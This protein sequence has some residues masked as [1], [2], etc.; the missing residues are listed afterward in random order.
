MAVIETPTP[1]MI[2][3]YQAWLAG[4]PPQVRAVAERF[5]PWELY[6]LKTSKHRVIVLSFGETMDGRVELTVLV[7]GQ[8]NAV[9]FDRQV[10]GINPDDLEPCEL[11]TEDE[12]LG[13]MMT[14]EEV[15]ENIDALRAMAGIT[16]KD[17]PCFLCG[18][19]SGVVDTGRS[20][21]AHCAVCHRRGR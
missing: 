14:P 16:P 19:P 3:E 10:F 2:A 1:D 7:S 11:P 6:R 4:R 18:Q 20:E 17:I 8:F 12:V 9:M 5:R 21:I 15:D 13:T